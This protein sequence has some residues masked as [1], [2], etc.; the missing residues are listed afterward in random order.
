MDGRIAQTASRK[1]QARR[2]K[3]GEHCSMPERANYDLPA[4]K[5]LQKF[6]TLELRGVTPSG[7]LLGE[8]NRR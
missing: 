5:L 2:H 3:H 6:R 8:F 7:Y 4:P 1:P